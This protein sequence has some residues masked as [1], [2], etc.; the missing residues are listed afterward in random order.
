MKITKTSPLTGK[1]NTREIA[2]TEE[3]L[4]KWQNREGLIQDIMPNVSAE[5]REFLISGSTPEDWEEMFGGDDEDEDE[6]DEDE[7]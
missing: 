5:D 2:I 1:Q 6:L 4:Q 7:E 3:Q